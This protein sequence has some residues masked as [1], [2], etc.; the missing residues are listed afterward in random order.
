MHEDRGGLG[1]HTIILINKTCNLIVYG[2]YSD[3]L[4]NPL[5]DTGRLL[6][7][8]SSS[9]GKDSVDQRGGRGYTAHERQ[10]LGSLFPM[11][12]RFPLLLDSFQGFREKSI[13]NQNLKC[14]KSKKKEWIAR[15]YNPPE[16]Q[17]NVLIQSLEQRGRQKWYI[18]E[19]HRLEWKLNGILQGRVTH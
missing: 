13:L 3:R 10:Y 6:Y 2:M 5:R 4:P 17:K 12:I 19:Q 7:H 8:W 11:S 1:K 9:L 16:R 15:C 18:P 14:G